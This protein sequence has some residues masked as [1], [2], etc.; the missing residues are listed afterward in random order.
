MV[1]GRCIA[2]VSNIFN[3]RHIKITQISLGEVE[4][5]GEVSKIDIQFIENQLNEIGFEKAKLPLT[6]FTVEEAFG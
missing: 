5:E 1:C 4:T 6:E 2:A 3:E